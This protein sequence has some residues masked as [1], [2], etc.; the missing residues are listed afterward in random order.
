MPGVVAWLAFNSFRRLSTML[1]AYRQDTEQILKEYGRSLNTVTQYYKDN[2]ELVKKWERVTN[3]LH[4]T[5]VLNTQVLQKV[6]DQILFYMREGR[7]K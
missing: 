1:E 6:S 2:V 4:S 3:D 5:V 7:A